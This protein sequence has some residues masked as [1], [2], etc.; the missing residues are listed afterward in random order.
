M[1]IGDM[2]IRTLAVAGMV[3]L[4]WIPSIAGQNRPAEGFDAAASDARAVAIADA[5]MD[6]MGGREAWDNTRYLTWRFFGKRLHVWD[7]WTGD[8]RVESEDRESG[9]SY[10][11]LSNLS[12]GDGRVWRNGEELSGAELSEALKR[13][14]SMW[15]NDSYWVFMP[16]KL[17]DT[18]VTLGYRGEG[19]MENGRVADVLE[20]TFENVGDTPQ[21][22]YHVWVA[23]DTGLV[24][25]WAYFAEAS[26]AEPRFVIP[27]NNWQRYGSIMLSDDRGEGRA[28]SGIAVLEKLPPG[29]FELTLT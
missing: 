5:T 1:R 6:A 17:K 29:A 19:E 18:G 8:F 25:Q 28:H 2:W 24:E 23:R 15:I 10:V 9:D 22:K 13:A 11:T 3:G 27:W 20:L 21:N 7:K 4:C 12:S 14:Q 26:D 16:Y